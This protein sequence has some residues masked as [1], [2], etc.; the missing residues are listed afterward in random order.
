VIAERPDGRGLT[1]RV[2]IAPVAAGKAR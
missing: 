1:A 2:E